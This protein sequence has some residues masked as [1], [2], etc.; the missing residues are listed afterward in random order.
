[1]IGLKIKLL[2]LNKL[3]IFNLFHITFE[4]EVKEFQE[5]EM[6]ILFTREGVIYQKEIPI[7]AIW[8]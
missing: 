2:N 1:M 8:K 5:L 4:F 6:E 7:E 3:I